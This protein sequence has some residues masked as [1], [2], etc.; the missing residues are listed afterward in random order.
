MRYCVALTGLRSQI[1]SS[2]NLHEHKM[3]CQD[4]PEDELC[5]DNRNETVHNSSVV[6]VAGICNSVGGS[7]FI[8]MPPRCR[9][10]M[11]YWSVSRLG[12][13]IGK[14]WMLRLQDHSCCSGMP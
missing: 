2:V 3:K 14:R 11:E 10:R 7:V 8:D 1:R 5:P 12:L 6:M 13:L 4:Q 9:W